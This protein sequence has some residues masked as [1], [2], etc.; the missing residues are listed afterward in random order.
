MLQ[1]FTFLGYLLGWSLRNLG[2]LSIDLPLA[3]WRRVCN[4]SQ[5]YTYTIQDLKEMDSHR[6]EFLTQ[7]INQS[8]TAT[9]EEF[10]A[11][12][13]GY[14]FEGSFSVGN[15]LINT[16]LCPGGASIELNRSNSTE[17]VELYLKKLTDLEN[18]QFERVFMAIQDTV[19]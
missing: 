1:K 17:F 6:A 12:Y 5:N 8:Q 15:N 7:M 14:T 11:L 2:G 4:G 13:N 16:D 19:G 9:E 10:S 3:F 18:L